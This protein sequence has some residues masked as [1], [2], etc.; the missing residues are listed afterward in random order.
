MWRFSNL[1]L[2]LAKATPKQCTGAVLKMQSAI[3][4]SVKCEFNNFRVA[5]CDSR[6]LRVVSYNST[7]L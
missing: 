4:V 6:N 5:S 3:C 2:I 7:S 1:P